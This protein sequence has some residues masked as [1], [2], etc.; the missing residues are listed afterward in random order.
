MV[1]V[2]LGEITLDQIKEADYV[3]FA[4]QKEEVCQLQFDR[5]DQLY[6]TMHQAGR[7]AKNKIAFSFMGYEQDR[8]EIFEIPEVREFVLQLYQKHPDLF[9][10]LYFKDHTAKVLLSCM[11]EVVNVKA[12]NGTTRFGIKPDDKL[13]EDVQ[14]RINEY[15]FMV[16][17]S[18]PATLRQILSADGITK[19]EKRYIVN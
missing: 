10:F 3:G 11:L 5:V 7:K 4:I 17:D 12:Q 6:E 19:I 18:Q 9:Y 16:N 15:A 14:K 2:L 8:R 13:F 1:N